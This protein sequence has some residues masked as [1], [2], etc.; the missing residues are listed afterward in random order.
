ME[1]FTKEYKL[2]RMNSYA[3]TKVTER[4]YNLTIGLTLLWGVLIN[5]VMSVFFTYQIL[6]LNYLLVLA[7]YFVGTIGCSILVHKSDSPAVSFAGFTG[8]AVSMGLLL[9][10]YVTV[11]TAHSVSYAFIATALVTVIMVI[12]SMLYPAFFQNLGRTLF[13]SLLACIIIQV[14]GAFLFRLPMSIIDYAVA[15]I[16]CGYI[17]L[18]W[19]RAQQYPKTLDNAIDCAADIYLDV[20]NLFI[21]IR[22]ITGKR[23]K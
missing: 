19:C 7:V 12:L 9:T 6:S 2:E 8:M 11:F 13:I 10:F 18:D 16:F 20:V 23:R 3:G 4:S 1:D 14:A 5:V 21:R 22:A 15:L 17:G